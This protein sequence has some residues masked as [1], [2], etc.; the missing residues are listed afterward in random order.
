MPTKAWIIMKPQN[1]QGEIS[2]DKWN[3]SVSCFG[4]Q[5]LLM[6]DHPFTWKTC[7]GLLRNP[8]GRVVWEHG[9]MSPT[10]TWMW[11]PS[12]KRTLVNR[13]I[14]LHSPASIH[15]MQM[16]GPQHGGSHLCWWVMRSFCRS[17]NTWQKEWL[18]S[19]LINGRPTGWS[20]I[21]VLC[22]LKWF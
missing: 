15:S 1:W 11:L 2:P 10:H 5:C 19:P 13:H 22:N 3:P 14:Q 8:F 7:I 6:E 16:K 17:L 21:Q 4:K 20:P 12:A 9:L 18:L